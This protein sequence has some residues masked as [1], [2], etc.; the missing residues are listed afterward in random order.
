MKIN[1]TARV[2][3]LR[4]VAVGRYWGRL[5]V[6]LGVFGVVGIAGDAG[7][8][9]LLCLFCLEDMILGYQHYLF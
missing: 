3:F 5:S 6:S 7:A 9:G 2:T 8:L 4:T 1:A